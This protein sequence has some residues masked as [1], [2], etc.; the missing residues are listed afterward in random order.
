MKSSLVLIKG[1]SVSYQLS[2]C[3]TLGN[4]CDDVISCLTGVT[5]DVSDNYSIDKQLFFQK[6]FVLIKI[7]NTHRNIFF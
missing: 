6:H 4:T 5:E 7:T 1:R 2:M 3:I